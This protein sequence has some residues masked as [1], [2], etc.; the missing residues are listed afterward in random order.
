MKWDNWKPSKYAVLCEIHF[1]RDDYVKVEGW[2]SLKSV[3]KRDA[4]PSVFNFPPH[5]KKAAK[6]RT[7]VKRKAP[8]PKEVPVK[9]PRLSNQLVTQDPLPENKPLPPNPAVMQDPVTENKPLPP[10]PSVI[11]DPVTE[12]KPLPPNPSVIEDLS[13]ENKPL[14]RNP[15]VMQDRVAENKPKPPTQSVMQDHNYCTSPSKV[16]PRLRRSL[17]KKRKKIRALTSKNLRKEKTI[18]GLVQKLEN[19]RHLSK[20]Q[21]QS[22]LSN[23][24]HMTKDLFINERKYANKSK[25]ARY[26]DTIKQF[27]VTLHFYSPKAYRFVRKSLHLPCSATIRAWAASIKCEPGFMTCIIEHLQNTLDEDDK[28]CFLLV[29]EMSIKKQVIWDKK[30]KKF[31]GT[32]DYGPILAEEQDSIAQNA[33]VVMAVGLKKPWFHPIIAYFLVDR[34]DAQMQAQ[35]IK[36]AVNLLTDAGLDVHGV[37]FDGCAKNIATARC[38]GCNFAKFDGSFKHP[39]RPNTTL[40][41][42][43]DVCHMLK[44]A[45]NS[46]G[47]LKVFY[48]ESGDIISWQ[49]ITRLYN[50]QKGDLLNLGNKLKST[51]I[52]WHNQKMKVAVAVIMYLRNLKLEQFKDG[53]ETAEFISKINNMFDILN[54]KSK[55]GKSYKAPITL[56]NLDELRHN[57]LDTISYLT[58]LKDSNGV[59]LIDGPRKTFILGFAVSSKSIMALA[60]ELLTRTHNKFDYVLTY[61]FSQDQLEMFFSKIRSRLGWNTNPNA[62]Q[63]KWALRALLQKNQVM[64]AETGNCSVIEESK[65]AEE[66]DDV[67]TRVAGLLNNSTMWHE[68]VLAYIGGYIAKKI[69]GCI[70]CA[71]CAI[72]LATDDDDDQCPLPDD[73][74]YS[75]SS[76]KSSLISFK[77]FGKLTNPS[78]SVVT[79]VEE[80]DRLLRLMVLKWSHLEDKAIPTLQRDVLQKVRSTAFPSLQQHSR[81]THP[82]DQNLQ[83]DHI[84]NLIKKI[85]YLYSKIFLYQFGKVYTD[86]VVKKGAPS[87]RQKLNKLILFGND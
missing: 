30:N 50:I 58:E 27:A 43:L 86:R 56:Q 32:T 85:T 29:D 48:T 57:L 49:Y 6:G 68:D 26:R 78:S 55:F 64:A 23:F 31:A 44:L 47:D 11:E 52:R 72:A 21:S 69:T 63:F 17:D 80:A 65:F 25:S 82:L 10:N 33:L 5:L 45:R 40:Y 20:E 8:S 22:L 9:K 75:K 18:K 36:E 7:P 51:H 62:L 12:N 77:T 84:T 34:V 42:I 73:H 39:T 14:P 28:D 79:V 16:I 76:S 81:E 41:V 4:V 66:A 24:G 83:D 3:L 74:A 59:K 13:P 61:R 54:S 46:L 35:I 53:N 60:K 1:T 19:A 15:T 87:K 38:L 67:D 37:T 70:K 2:K 71:E